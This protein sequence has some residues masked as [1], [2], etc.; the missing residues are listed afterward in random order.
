M[1]ANRTRTRTPT[2][3]RRIIVVCINRYGLSFAENKTPNTYAR[4]GLRFASYYKLACTRCGFSFAGPRWKQ[5]RI[6]DCNDIIE[7][8]KRG[9]FKRYN[10]P[11]L[12]SRNLHGE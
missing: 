7:Q 11:D 3:R 12:K 10:V 5:H 9:D 6:A 8:E 1:P 2:K 4:S